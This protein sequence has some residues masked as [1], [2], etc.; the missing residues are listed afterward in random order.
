MGINVN[1]T[2]DITRSRNVFWHSKKKKKLRNSIPKERMSELAMVSI[3]N[4]L[5]I[6]IQS[7]AHDRQV[8][9]NKRKEDRFPVSDV[10]EVSTLKRN[11]SLLT[12][13]INK[14]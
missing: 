10:N 4:D 5:I 2:N 3:K 7:S 8:C 9:L 14:L 11:V 12:L 1:D 6:E 13:K